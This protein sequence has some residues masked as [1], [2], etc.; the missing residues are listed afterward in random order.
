MFS[1]MSLI[2]ENTVKVGDVLTSLTIFISLIFFIISM[3]KDRS[4]RRKQQADNVRN[5]AAR[6]I[7]KLDRWK[8]ISLSMFHYMDIAFVESSEL[9]KTDY[10]TESVRNFLWMELLV[11]KNNTSEKI[12]NENI[13][14]AYDELYGY[15]PSVRPFFEMVLTQLKREE[16]SMFEGLLSNTQ[17][18]IKSFDYKNKN[19]YQT[20]ILRN[21]LNDRVKEARKDY[22]K[23]INE[24]LKPISDNLLKLICENDK[25]ILEKNRDYCEIKFKYLF[26]WDEIPGKENDKF[27]EIIET[28]FGISWIKTAE[29]KKTDD[30]MT[31]TAIEEM[32]SLSLKR[33]D[34]KNEVILEINGEKRYD[35][36]LKREYGDLN[37]YDNPIP[38]IRPEHYTDEEFLSGEIADNSSL[39]CVG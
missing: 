16:K 31:I 37:V 9:L 24:I 10:N 29:M 7:G 4:L 34:E 20:S 30:D 5:A 15:D 1:E 12:L 19:E 3:N 26:T 39:F 8:E 21:Q 2:I 35:F 25:D 28:K 23:S 14:T 32:K 13:E 11:I 18:D 27:V 6:T 22:E 36:I 17:S 33:N 38:D